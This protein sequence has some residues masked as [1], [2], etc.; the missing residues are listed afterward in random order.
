M[1]PLYH[2]LTAEARHQALSEAE[3]V[4]K[5]A[6]VVFA[7]FITRFAPVRDIAIDQPER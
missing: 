7:A 6:G 4:L 2:L 3:R 1:G 5:P